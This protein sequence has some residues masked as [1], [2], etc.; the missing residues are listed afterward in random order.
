MTWPTLPLPRLLR[1]LLFGA[2]LPLVAGGQET[3][4][5]PG[6]T[7]GFP[8]GLTNTSVIAL[9]QGADGLIY[10]GTEGGLF[11]FDGRRFEPLDLPTDHRFITALL[12]G[13]DGR[14]WVGTRNGLGWL[15]AD[16]AFHTEVGPLAQRIHHL[17]FDARGDL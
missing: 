1:S 11:R 15:D 4:R 9:A 12:A 16:W 10:A 17:G 3:G 5:Y 7:Y 13:P 2:L 6:R 14:L 8:E